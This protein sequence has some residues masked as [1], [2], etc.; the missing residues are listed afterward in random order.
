MSLDAE[1]FG[2]R[3]LRSN[4]SEGAE[5]ALQQALSGGARS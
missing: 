4:L 5:R 2:G 3:V 1:Q